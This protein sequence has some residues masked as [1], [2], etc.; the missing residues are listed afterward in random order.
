MSLVGRREGIVLQSRVFAYIIRTVDSRYR[1]TGSVPCSEGDK[2]FFGPCK[3]QMRPEVKKGDYILGISGSSAPRP[4]RILLWMK[5]RKPI[6]FKAAW[7]LGDTDPLFR[8]LRGGAIHIRPRRG[9]EALPTPLC[10]EHLPG[11]QHEDDWEDDVRDNRDVFLLGDVGSW[12]ADKNG[13]E[14][15]P[16]IVELLKT[17]ITWAGYATPNNPL[18]QYARGK[19]ALLTGQAANKIISLVPKLKIVAGKKRRKNGCGRNC[20]CE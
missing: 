9:S 16:E 10:Y 3:R 15:T 13:P 5:A 14:V 19:H 2:V 8:K 7:R 20:E 17:G 4:R 12:I 11:A 6:T 1:V 18:T